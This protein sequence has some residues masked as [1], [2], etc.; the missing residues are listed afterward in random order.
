MAIPIVADGF[1]P[2]ESG[3]KVIVVGAGKTSLYS[4]NSLPNPQI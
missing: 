3:I 4:D 2:P 1:I